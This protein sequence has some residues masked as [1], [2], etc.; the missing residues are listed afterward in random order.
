MNQYTELYNEIKPLLEKQSC[1]VMNAAREAA[2]AVFKEKGLPTKKVERYRYT[3]VEASFAPDYGVQLAPL[4][5]K[6]VPYVY[7]IKDAPT[8]AVALYNSVADNSDALTALNTALAHD[9]LVVYVPK[10]TKV[11]TPIRIENSMSGDVDTM[12]VRRVL[13]VMEQC[14]EA[15]V[16]SVQRPSAGDSGKGRFLSLETVEI[17][18]GD[19]V[20]LDMYDMEESAVNNHRFKNIYIKVGRDANVRHNGITLNNGVTRNGI[21]VYLQGEGAEVTLNGA[22]I[23][24]GEQHV[25]VNTVID[26]QVPRCV[27]NEL[28]KY[29][30]DDKAVTAFA[31]KILVREGAQQTLSNERN[32]NMC[33]SEEARV[34]TQPMLEIYADDVKCAH[35]STVGVMDQAALFYMQQRGIPLEEARTLLKNAF[36][37]EVLEEMHWESFRDRM[38]IL[39]DKKLSHEERCKACNVCK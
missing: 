9:T 30:A 33:A 18:A 11:T 5:I 38:H 22:V 20:H 6:D 25:D 26:H 31:G 37:A 23:A 39:V 1:D 3:D 12:V 24:D 27:S 34:Y 28:Y 16:L 35:G 2:M 29:V 21:D 36:I 14:S 7:A 13:I 17:V 15:T 8:E 10:N 32:N 4:T 19:G